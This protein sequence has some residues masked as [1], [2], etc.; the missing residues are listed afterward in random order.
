VL[1][2]SKEETCNNIDDDCNGYIDDNNWLAGTPLKMRRDDPENFCFGQ[3]VCEY[4]AQMC[5]EGVW[6][7]F[8]PIPYGDEACDGLDNDCDGKTDEDTETE[9]LF[10]PDE[11]YVYTADPDTINIGECRA[12]YKECIAGD[13]YIRNMRTPVSEICGNGD[14]D[15][16]DGLT[17]EDEND[18]NSV[19]YLFVI[20]FSGSMEN[21]INSLANSL[22]S[23]SSQGAVQNSRF[24]VI[25]VGHANSNTENQ[26]LLLTDF[27]DSNTACA[28]IQQNNIS[29]NYGNTEYQLDAVYNSSSQGT[30]VGSMML[31]W[32]D[33]NDKKVFIFSDEFLQQNFTSDVTEAI[34]LVTEQC[35]AANYSIGAFVDYNTLNQS[36]W[37]E[38]TQNCNGFLDYLTNNTQD[39]IDKLNY[40]VGND[41]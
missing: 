36:E 4:A 37:V 26:I 9:P 35:I 38:L 13:V 24:A 28:V 31:S 6:Q 39:M 18:Q 1:F 19:D 15:D 27:T 33:E 22:C 32:N 29:Q 10:S 20:D 34:R 30:R 40:W 25:A 8:Y 12:G 11:R 21:I 3:G 17:D 16:C 5:I 2:R 14:D 23:W 7:C 41:C